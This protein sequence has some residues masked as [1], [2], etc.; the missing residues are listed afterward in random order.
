M[1]VKNRGKA[2]KMKSKREEQKKEFDNMSIYLMENAT[3]IYKILIGRYHFSTEQL[4][5]IVYLL[6]AMCQ[7]DLDFF[8]R[9]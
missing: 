3:E 7:I 8:L 1:D 6:D 5:S 9:I 4:K 2:E